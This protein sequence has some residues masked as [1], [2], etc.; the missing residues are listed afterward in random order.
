[1]RI[2]ILKKKAQMDG[3]NIPDDAIDYIASHIEGNIFK[4]EGALSRTM[5]YASQTDQS[6]TKELVADA[7]E[8]IFMECEKPE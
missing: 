3:I 6:I 5:A 8:N 2:N 4:L 7:L 1:M